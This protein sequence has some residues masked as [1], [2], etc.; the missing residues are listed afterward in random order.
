M[1]K[2]AEPLERRSLMLFLVL[3]EALVELMPKLRICWP[4]MEF[5][6]SKNKK[7]GFEGKKWLKYLV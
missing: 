1:S 3:L 2:L 7:F 6:Q 5:C 4:E